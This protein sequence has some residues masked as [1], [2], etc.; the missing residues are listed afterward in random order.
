MESSTAPFEASQTPPEMTHPRQHGYLFAYTII[1]ELLRLSFFRRE[2][3]RNES[4]TVQIL[5]SEWQKLAYLFPP[6]QTVFYAQLPI[7]RFQISP[8]AYAVVI[9]FGEPKRTL[10]VRYVVI[11][12]TPQVSC[13]VVGLRPNSEDVYTLRQVQDAG[14]RPVGRIASPTTEKVLTEICQVLEM[15]C[16]IQ[17]ATQEQ[18]NE[19]ASSMEGLTTEDQAI[20]E[21]VKQTLVEVAQVA[22]RYSVVS[23][24]VGDTSAMTP[25]MVTEVFDRFRPE[26]REFGPA[27]AAQAL[28][29]LKAEGGRIQHAPSA[30]S[31]DDQT[32][33]VFR[34]KLTNAVAGILG[35]IILI[36]LGL[37]IGAAYFFFGTEYHPHGTLEC[38]IFPAAFTLAGFFL[39]RFGI[40][41]FRQTITLSN[42]GISRQRGKKSLSFHWD[43]IIGVDEYRFR[44]KSIVYG[45][46]P[47][48]P[49]KDVTSIT[50]L[51]KNNKSLRVSVNSVSDMG[52][53]RSRLFELTQHHGAFWKIT[54]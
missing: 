48:A 21:N 30:P 14:H 25:A 39:G 19:A 20:G 51:A 50:V 36:T 5:E 16:Q 47:L 42:E 43:E 49:R 17:V 45:N 38:Y 18:L 37:G 12:Y 34:P 24:A 29:R 15:D 52:A 10:D 4:E 26:V 27:F 28:E 35:G 32:R 40:N 31:S 9:E 44:E 54:H 13:F 11:T 8:N 41:L 22:V 23:R 6:E 46:M 7:S 53:F 33:I 2:L 1:P 3:L